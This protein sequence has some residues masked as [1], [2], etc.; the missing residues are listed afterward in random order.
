MLIQEARNGHDDAVSNKS[1]DND[2]SS[3]GIK[4]GSAIGLQEDEQ[5]NVEDFS[6][7]S[8]KKQQTSFE[9]KLIKK[10]G[11]DYENSSAQ[12]DP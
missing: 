8:P 12:M 6:L 9:K 11:Q 10:L 2:P 1:T 5:H 3:S 7:I 4:F